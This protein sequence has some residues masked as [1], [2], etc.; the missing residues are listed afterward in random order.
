MC[1]LCEKCGKL[2]G[3][4]LLLLGVAFLLVDLGVWNFWNVSWYSAL[5]LLG[6]LV[7]LGS[8]LCPD[9]KLPA[10]PVKKK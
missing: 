10:K 2:A 6:G 3:V 4:V 1:N 5:I 9:C 7:M 8:N